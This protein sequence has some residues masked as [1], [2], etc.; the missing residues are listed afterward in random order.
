MCSS[1]WGNDLSLKLTYN[2]HTLNLANMIF[3]FKLYLTSCR[4]QCWNKNQFGKKERNWGPTV[5]KSTQMRLVQVQQISFLGI[6]KLQKNKDRISL[7]KYHSHGKRF[8]HQS[9]TQ[10]WLYTKILNDKKNKQLSKNIEMDI[11]T[12]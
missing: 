10:E 4:V 9:S 5:G 7:S 3:L 2:R 11:E 6:K 12:K 1:K 8:E